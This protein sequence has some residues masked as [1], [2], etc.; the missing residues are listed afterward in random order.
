[1]TIAHPVAERIASLRLPG[2]LAAFL[3]QMARHD[4]DTMPFEDRLSLLIDREI[5]ER[6]SRAL[7]RRLKKA[8]L[9]HQDACFEDI[10]LSHPRG[11]PRRV[12]LGLA[13]CTWIRSSANILITGPCGTGKS[14][15]AC[16]L[17]HKACL[18]GYQALYLRGPR[19]LTDLRIAHG[20]G[21]I[22]RLYRDLARIDLLI[23]DDWALAPI[24]AARARDLLEILD[25]RFGHRSVIVTSQLPVADWHRQV[26]DLSV[27][28]A[29]LDRLVHGAIRFELSG[30]SM[31]NPTTCERSSTAG[32]QQAPART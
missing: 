22:P 32:G 2:M 30:S 16:A 17:A 28:D 15:I 23:I 26:K 5:D 31:R 27:A 1:M 29:I 9:R 25:D 13:D 24:D 8:R 6:R 12:V 19:L 10:N 20:E 14:W 11:L 7:Q 21:T 18:E 4:L 3:E